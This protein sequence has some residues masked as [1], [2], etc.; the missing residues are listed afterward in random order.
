MQESPDLDEL[1]YWGLYMADFRR[2][3]QIY[4]FLIQN[5]H[6]LVQISFKF[7]PQYPV[8]NTPAN[9]IGGDTAP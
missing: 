4:I 7:V 9:P 3:F 2:H 8:D 1:T 5:Y 6:I